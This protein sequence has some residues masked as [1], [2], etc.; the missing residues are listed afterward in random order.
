MANIKSLRILALRKELSFAGVKALASLDGLTT[1][2]LD[3]PNATAAWLNELT[4][5]KSLRHLNLGNIRLTD[6]GLR[7]LA[8]LK[9]L[10]TLVFYSHQV[11]DEGVAAFKREVPNC[12]VQRP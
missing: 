10:N 8:H 12:F 1:L 4:R 7:T 6:K 11:T 9:E 2:Y 5:L 3:S